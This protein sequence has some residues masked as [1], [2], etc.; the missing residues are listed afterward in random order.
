MQSEEVRLIRKRHP[1]FFCFFVH[2]SPNGRGGAAADAEFGQMVQ[3]QHGRGTG[4]PKSEK[5][6]SET[7][8]G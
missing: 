3:P 8:N 6:A 5:K 7:E 1:R 2:S 4:V